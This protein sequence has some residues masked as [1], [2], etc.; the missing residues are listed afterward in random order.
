MAIE[1]YRKYKLPVEIGVIRTTI[2]EI[3]IDTSKSKYYSSY[4]FHKG[5]IRT[6]GR[7][8][9][10]YQYIYGDFDYSSESR[11]KRSK[12]TSLYTSYGT[13]GSSNN[14]Q[15]NVTVSD[16]LKD[17]YEFQKIL[18]RGS[19]TI[20]GTKYNDIIA[21]HGGN[22][23]IY[24]EGGND[25]IYADSGD[26]RIMGGSGD[27]HI[28][29]RSGNDV[30]I[31]DF[32]V[33]DLEFTFS[34]GN[35]RVKNNLNGD[36]DTLISIERINAKDSGGSYQTW[37]IKE[38]LNASNATTVKK[39]YTLNVYNNLNGKLSKS[40]T[41]K[42]GDS[43][44][45]KVKVTG[46]KEGK[47]L[48]WRFSPSYVLY[49]LSDVNGN[50]FVSGESIGSAMID[51]NG[52][53]SVTDTFKIDGLN[54]YEH[55][56]IEIFSD[57]NRLNLVANSGR[58]II[59]NTSIG[60]TSNTE[61]TNTSS[62]S[63]DSTDDLE[64]VIANIEEWTPIPEIELTKGSS[65]KLTGIKDYGG[66]SHAGA[67][68][69]AEGQYKYKGEVDLNGDGVK[70]KVFTNKISGR[71]ASLEV[72]PTT[73]KTNYSDHGEGGGTRVVGIYNDPLVLIGEV[74]KGG[75]HD[76]QTRFQNDLYADN[77]S[78]G[79]GGDFDSDGTDEVYWRT[80]DD[81]AYL[82]SLHHADGNIQYANYQSLSQMTSYLTDTGNSNL[83]S[84]V[85]G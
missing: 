81:S 39:E 78:L 47:R 62:E 24:G 9:S 18:L 82:R 59:G 67:S 14:T 26:D 19:D 55:M 79:V 77:L 71:W 70:E 54:D 31:Y 12:I 35:Y 15:A 75:P 7:T 40:D 34:E 13:L 41:F 21:S 74:E 23:I 65:Y 30:A 48:Y 27:D 43:F 85:V 2:P 53:L 63:S 29:G 16:V 58:I 46:E 4:I 28:E 64:K 22:D 50:D 61:E 76:S 8:S 44:T 52:E 83:I 6:Q 25:T 73:G 11:Y 32:K 33:E 45:F 72:D 1:D 20:Y 10:Y 37:D 69:N 68:S 51:K 57:S 3:D 80:N 5:T 84:T 56:D 60:S 49:T 38:L 17:P 36:V 42:E 66:N